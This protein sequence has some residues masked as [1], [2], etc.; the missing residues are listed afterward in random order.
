[1]NWLE[2]VKKSLFEDHTTQLAVWCEHLWFT[3]VILATDR[4]QEDHCSKQIQ[5]NSL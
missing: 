5:A 4:D 1:M 2:R 3:L